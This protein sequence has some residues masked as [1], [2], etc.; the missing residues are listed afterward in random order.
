M[1]PPEHHPRQSQLDRN[2]GAL[3]MRSFSRGKEHKAA[4]LSPPPPVSDPTLELVRARASPHLQRAFRPAV[5]GSVN[6]QVCAR[7][8][9]ALFAS[10]GSLP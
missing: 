10:G 3:L 6:V 4:A 7:C 1:P 2:L 8:H 5:S 9:L